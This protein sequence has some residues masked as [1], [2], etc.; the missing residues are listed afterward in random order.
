MFAQG[1]GDLVGSR[2]AVV[3]V[4]TLAKAA[5]TTDP[6]PTRNC[7]QPARP[8]ARPTAA[9]GSGVTRRDARLADPVAGR[10]HAVLPER[11]QG[12]RLDAATL[13]KGSELRLAD[14]TDVMVL[15]RDGKTLYG[16]R[17][18]DEPAR[19]QFD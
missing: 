18:V 11:G 3:K 14:G 9:R 12:G 17:A 5:S 13:K 2:D 19:V 15:A 6:R 16:V 10:P 1:R 7:D 8:F 4:W